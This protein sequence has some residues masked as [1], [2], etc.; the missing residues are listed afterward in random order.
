MPCRGRILAAAVTV[1]SKI[2]V[3]PKLVEYVEPMELLM[4][5][6]PGIWVLHALQENHE[7]G[8]TFVELAHLRGTHD[9][10]SLRQMATARGSGNVSGQAFTRGFPEYV[11]GG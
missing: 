1:Y 4:K 7:H 8:K 6:M 3:L 5:T 2:S 11:S 10:T 9:L